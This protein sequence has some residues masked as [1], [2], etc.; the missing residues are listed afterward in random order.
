MKG[1]LGSVRYARLAH[2]LFLVCLLAGAA[3]AQTFRGTILGNVTDQSGAAVAGAKVTIRNSETGQVRETDTTNDGTYVAPELPLGTYTVTVEKGGFKTSV[4]KDVKVDVASETRVNASL[5]A[6]E[7]ST[8]VE[9]SGEIVPLVETTSDTQGGVIESSVAGNLPVNGRDYTKL[10]YLVPGVAGSPDQIT[11]SP[12]SYGTF[13]M[14]GARGRANNFLLDG[15]DM[16]DGYRNDP[17]I[18]EAGVFGTPATILPVES[19]AEIRVISNFEAEYGRSA[20]AVINIVTKSGTNAFH[21]TAAEFVRNTD[22]NARNYFNFDPEP[23]SPF[24]NNQ[25]GGSLGGPITKDKTFFFIDYEGQQESGG[26]N[27]LACVPDPSLLA[28]A[29]NPVIVSL[30]KLNP[31][32]APNLPVASDATGCP[33]G[34]NLSATTNFTNKLSSGIIKLDHNFN[35]N[36]I[37]TGRYYIGDSTQSF[38]LALTGGGLLPGYNTNT[39]TRVQL[40]SLSLVSVLSPRTVNE[41]RGGWIRFAEGFY[42]Q[43]QSFNPNSIGL[44]TGVTSALDFGLPVINVSGFAQLGANASDPRNRV[45]SNWHFID[46]V[47][48][49]T[50]KHDLKFGYEFRRTTVSQNF[51]HNYRG[52]LSFSSLDDFLDGTVD[53]GSQYSGYSNRNTYEN[54]HALYAQDS[55]RISPKL[56]VNLGVRWDYYGVV[57]EKNGLFE[58]FSFSQGLYQ[59]N[60]LYKPDYNN[61][62]PRLSFAY[63]LT[64]KGKTVFRAGYGIFYDAV[65]Q[66]LFMGHLPYPSSYA[67]GPAYSG[68]GKDP[69]SV[70]SANSGPLAPGSPVYGNFSPVGDAFGVD[71]NMRTPYMEN[72]NFNIQQ[73]LGSRATLQVGYIGSA[74]RKLYRFVDLNQPSQSQ[75]DAADLAAGMSASYGVPRSYSA[76]YYIY[77]EQAAASSNYNS[78]QTSVRIH[79]WHGLQGTVNYVWSHSI[80]NASDGEDFEPNQAQPNDSTNIRAEKGNSSFDIRNRFTGNFIYEFPNR[81]GRFEK[82]SNGWGLNGVL[83]LQTGQPFQLNYNFEGDYDGSGNGDG[84][85]DV[86]GP[87]QYNQHDPLNFLNLSSFA[88]PCTLDGTGTADTNC[89]PGTRHYGNEGRNALV[90]PSFKNFDLSLFKRTALT[91]RV[92]LELRM[93]VYNLFNHPNFTNPELPNFIADAAP[94]GINSNGTSTGYYALGAT[95]DVSIGNPFLGGGGPRGINL[96]VKLSF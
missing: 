54:N 21:G 81:K 73:S 49:K 22:L 86:V 9:V 37:L 18:N 74:G 38:P 42:P 92:N 26:L 20:G 83:T 7:V 24:H 89:V 93:E 77:Q 43:D 96:G 33:N 64:G 70:G 58:N 95:P 13:S 32:P 34:P 6:G 59:T 46:N 69:I 75:I 5:Q 51:D 53:G 47:S 36:N 48:L 79:Q 91:E 23:K 60:Q 63:D 90:G 80:D 72:Y 76:L 85:P 71:P 3:M 14:N 17:A 41:V 52:K 8:T 78:L 10:I 4:T 29:T 61:F 94:N 27:S 15:T 2:A 45:D 25:F 65:S 84:R 62:A 55:I 87:I 66:D 57:G 12:G 39:P 19:V 50:G 31:W 40:I 35:S 82:L 68:T 30:L 67:P 16:N 56:T 88:V 1:F 44:D 28:T 11:D